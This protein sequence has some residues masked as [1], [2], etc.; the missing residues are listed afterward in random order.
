MK[1]YTNIRP[2]NIGLISKKVAW[3]FDYQLQLT[4]EEA[5]WIQ[6]Y[7]YGGM[8]VGTWGD[9]KNTSYI[10][11]SQACVGRKDMFFRNLQEPTQLEVSLIEGCK[12]LGGVLEEL[13]RI[14][15]GAT[16]VYEISADS[17]QLCSLAPQPV[18]PVS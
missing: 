11:V 7:Q 3:L 6:A 15:T 16:R 2:T 14:G 4:P 9:P 13:R 18:Q 1:L 8:T 12:S 10:N 5:A 17:V